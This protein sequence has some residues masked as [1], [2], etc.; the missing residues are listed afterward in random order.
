[1]TI[2]E[3]AEGYA[4]RRG[5]KRQQAAALRRRARALA[6]HVGR[7]DMAACF[8]VDSVNRFLAGLAERW[9]PATVRGYRVDLLTLWAAAADEGLADPPQRRLLRPTPVPDPLV[10]CFTVD[11]TRRILAAAGRLR[12]VYPDG[13]RAADYWPGVIRLAWDTGLR[14]ADCWGFQQQNVDVGGRWRVVQRKTGKLVCGVMWP[15]TVQAVRALHGRQPFRWSRR[16]EAFCRQFRR[17]VAAAGVRAGTFRW[18]RRSS[19]SYVEA[20]SPGAGWRH[21]GHGSPAVFRRHYDAQLAPPDWRPP[22]L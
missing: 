22:E 9:A 12:R 20:A 1:M 2:E 19:G 4:L 6:N 13:V 21:L 5:V 7:D 11:E 8:Q 15:S 3:F 18:L 17:I 14:R 16:P 10:E